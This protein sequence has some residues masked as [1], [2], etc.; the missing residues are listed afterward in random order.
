MKNL[1]RKLLNF[2][3][4]SFIMSPSMCAPHKLL[5]CQSQSWLWHVF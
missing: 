1:Q 5:K 2:R 4:S 3:N